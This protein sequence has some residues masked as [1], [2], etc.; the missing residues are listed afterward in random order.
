MWFINKLK[1]KY[2]EFQNSLNNKEDKIKT[3]ETPLKETSIH[4]KDKYGTKNKVNH[5]PNCKKI[6]QGRKSAIEDGIG[7]I[8]CSSCSYVAKLRNNIVVTKS[9]SDKEIIRANE[10]FIKADYHPTNFSYKE[11]S[12]KISLKGYVGNNKS[13]LFNKNNIDIE[14]VEDNIQDNIEEKGNIIYLNDYR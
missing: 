9:N 6:L 4:N 8:C 2:K 13:L 1:N 3:K 5:C 12:E 7:Y 14:E 11:N 10:L